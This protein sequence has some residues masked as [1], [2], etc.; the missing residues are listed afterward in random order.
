MV[1]EVGDKT[2]RMDSWLD[3]DAAEV[4]RTEAL[5]VEEQLPHPRSMML[6]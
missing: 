6:P 3:V 1:W 4:V 2:E 5:E